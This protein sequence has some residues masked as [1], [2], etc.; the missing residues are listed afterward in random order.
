MT[1][2]VVQS[3]D[4]LFKIAAKYYGDGYQYSKILAA[5]PQITNPDLIRVGDLVNIPGV[6]DGIVTTQLTTTD[7]KPNVSKQVIVLAALAALGAGA[8]WY[9]SSRNVEAA[10][11][12]EEDEDEDEE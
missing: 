8:F 10:A 1:A 5:N 7:E 11:N 4:T 9:F 6:D 2:Y 12:P 3:G